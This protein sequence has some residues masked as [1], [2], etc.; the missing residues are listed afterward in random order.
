MDFKAFREKEN[1]REI[2]SFQ[3]GFL[4]YCNRTVARGKAVGSEGILIYR[5]SRLDGVRQG[6]SFFVCEKGY[7]AVFFIYCFLKLL[8]VPDS[9]RRSR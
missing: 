8:G 9:K 3:S 4:V 6:G 1:G 7:C 5:E 2:S